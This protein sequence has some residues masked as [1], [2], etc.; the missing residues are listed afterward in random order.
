MELRRPRGQATFVSFPIIN[1]SCSPVTGLNSN[2]VWY[3]TFT[4]VIAPNTK[5]STLTYATLTE[6]GTTGWY[7]ASL[8][9][10]EMTNDYVLF[11]ASP[12]AGTG[13]PAKIGRAACRGR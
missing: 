13:R 9:A 5:F 11:L 7:Y 4:D 10:T 3:A 12:T 2:I 1:S 6:I 8:T